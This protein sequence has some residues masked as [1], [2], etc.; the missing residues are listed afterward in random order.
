MQN[1]F[2]AQFPL[3]P[4]VP[5]ARALPLLP[6]KASGNLGVVPIFDRDSKEGVPEFYGVSEGEY[7]FFTGTFPEKYH[8]PQ[9]R[10]SEQSQ[11]HC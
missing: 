8:P 10:N 2:L 6:W 9:K 1:A 7:A 5:F 4:S 11:M 3:P